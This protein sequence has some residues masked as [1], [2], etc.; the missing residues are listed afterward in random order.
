MSTENQTPPMSMS[1]RIEKLTAWAHT[2][3]QRAEDCVRYSG[4]PVLM[5]GPT[6]ITAYGHGRLSTKTYFSTG[7]IRAEYRVSGEEIETREI[8][9]IRYSLVGGSEVFEVDVVVSSSRG[10]TP[11]DVDEWVMGKLFGALTDST[12]ADPSSV[13]DGVYVRSVHTRSMG[14]RVR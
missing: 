9:P 6:I 4:G 12:Y 5:Y 10:M 1:E 8:G 3:E 14:E 13:K 7:E 2:K 11:A